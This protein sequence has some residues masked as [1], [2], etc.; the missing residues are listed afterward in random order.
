M[1]YVNSQ[2]F[3]VGQ[4]DL[5]H[6]YAKFLFLAFSTTPVEVL[7]LLQVPAE[8][9]FRGLHASP[10]LSK[11]RKTMGWQHSPEARGESSQTPTGN[12]YTWAGFLDEVFNLLMGLR[13][14]EVIFPL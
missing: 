13:H 3:R 7:N 1:P 5:S 9:A 4:G 8:L 11:V 14:V 12:Q 10:M 6:W 2:P